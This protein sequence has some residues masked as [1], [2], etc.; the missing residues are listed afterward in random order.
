M[1]KKINK[2]FFLAGIAGLLIAL[3][4]TVGALVKQS[5]TFPIVSVGVIVAVFAVANAAALAKKS[6]KA[7]DIKAQRE[8]ELAELDTEKLD[9]LAEYVLERAKKKAIRIKAE[10]CETTT[11]YD[12][13]FGGVPYWDA[14]E[15]YP[16]NS[17]GEKLAL[18]AQINFADFKSDLLPAESGILQIFANDEDDLVGCDYC[19]PS[20]QENYRVIYHKNLVETDEK[21]VRAAGAKVNT[22]RAGDRDYL[23]PF[24]AVYKLSFEEFDD[25]P[26][27][28]EDEC[29]GYFADA[30]KEL[31]G[32][33]LVE[34]SVWKTFNHTEY[35]YLAEKFGEW[36]HKM[37]GYADFT[38]SDPREADSK[39]DTQL[40]QIDSIDD[41]MWGDCGVA[42]FLINGEELKN[43][44]FSDVFYSWD[45]Y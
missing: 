28:G 8:K 39:Y 27:F 40:L 24:E 41:I 29:D 14:A 26:S 25:Y 7:A 15:K 21:T 38:Q 4:A 11:V 33:N 34:N 18:L 44:D 5:Y 22:D 10:K 1:N 19:A 6:T 36:G 23:Y 30:L 35:S 42:N 31:Y 43:L 45:C 17:K 12:S 3:G 2:Y 37:F 20:T 13:K 9:R 32:E 16:E